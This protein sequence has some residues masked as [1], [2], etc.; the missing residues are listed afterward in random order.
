MRKNLTKIVI[1]LG[2]IIINLFFCSFYKIVLAGTYSESD[3]DKTLKR[4]NGNI[5]ANTVDYL[6]Y[7]ASNRQDAFFEFNAGGMIKQNKEINI[8]DGYYDNYHTSN[9]SVICLSPGDHKWAKTQRV[10][11]IMDINVDGVTVYTQSNLEGKEFSRDSK[12]ANVKKAIELADQLAYFSYMS[13]K[14]NETTQNPPWHYYKS[15]MRFQIFGHNSKLLSDT[16]GIPEVFLPS[17]MTTDAKD[18]YEDKLEEW[19]KATKTYQYTGRIVFLN[20]TLLTNANNGQNDCIYSGQQK[21]KTSLKIKKVDPEGNPLK[22]VE[23]RVYESSS[24]EEKGDW[25]FTGLTNKNGV[26]NFSGEK[27][28]WYYVREYKTISGY[29]KAN[30]DHQVVKLTEDKQPVK[31]V[32]ERKTTL[33]IIKKDQY[34]KNVSGI[35]FWIWRVEKDGTKTYITAKRTN[36]EGVIEYK[37]AKIGEQYYF[38]EDVEDSKKLGYEP[39]GNTDA[40]ITI[41]EGEN[42]FTI[43]N[44]LTKPKLTIIKKDSKTG[45]LLPGA[46][47][48]IYDDKGN[49]VKTD[50]TNEDGKIIVLGEV[51]KTYR[52]KEVVPPTGYNLSSENSKDVFFKEGENEVEF[53][54]EPISTPSDEKYE[55]K[56]VKVD[57]E[58]KTH[59]LE[60][61]EFKIV[62][63]IKTSEP[64]G[65]ETKHVNC[66]HVKFYHLNEFGQVVAFE[67]EHPEGHDVEVN[68]YA[69][70]VNDYYIDASGNWVKGSVDS[71]Y[72]HKTNSKGIISLKGSMPKTTQNNDGTSKDVVGTFEGDITAIEVSNSNYGY[73]QESGTEHKVVIKTG[74]ENTEIENDQELGNLVIHKIDKRAYDEYGAKVPL[75]GVEFKIRTSESEYLQLSDSNGVV[76]KVNGKAVIDRYNETAENGTYI[77]KYVKSK[78][79]ATTFVTDENGIIR[80]ENLEVWKSPD[81]KYTYYMDEIA[82]GEK[83]ELYYEVK[84]QEEAKDDNITLSDKDVEDTNVDIQ[85]YQRYV[86][87]AGYIW[88]D[89]HQGKNSL[90][91]SVYKE[92]TSDKRIEQDDLPGG[93]KGITI[94]LMQGEEKHLAT[95]EAI[96][97]DITDEIDGKIK[98]DYFFPSQMKP[99]DSSKGITWVNPDG[100]KIEIDKLSEYYIE[101][102]YNG[103]KYQSVPAV[104]NLSEYLKL[105]DSSKAEDKNRDT[106]NNNF[107]SIKGGNYKTQN[108]TQG[109]TST[110][111]GLT[112]KSGTVEEKSSTLVQNTKYTKE[113]LNGSVSEIEK[114]TSKASTQD[115]YEIVF[116]PR[117]DKIRKTI[118]YINLGIY[119]REQADLAIATDLHNIGMSIN[120]YNHTYYYQKRNPY[121]EYGEKDHDYNKVDGQ[122]GYKAIMDAFSVQA[123]NRYTDSYRNLSYVRE[124]LPSYIAYTK[125]DPDRE[126]KLQV[127]VNYKIVVKNQ[128]TL[129]NKV[130]LRNYYDENYELIGATV[131]KWTPGKEANNGIRVCEM[132]Q[133][134]DVGDKLEIILTFELKT[135]AICSLA[136]GNGLQTKT[137]TTEIITYSTYKDGNNYA[138]IDKDSAPD[139]STYGD[140]T[141]YEDDIDAAPDLT[142]KRDDSRKKVLTGTVF[143]DK[144]EGNGTHKKDPNKVLKTEEDKKD[145]ET[146]E[147][148]ANGQYE[149]HEGKGQNVRVELVKRE[150]KD[151]N[152]QDIAE[153]DI[154]TVK[155]GDDCKKGHLLYDLD[156]NG[157]VIHPNSTLNN[158]PSD[159]TYK[160]VGLVPGIYYIRYTYGTEEETRETVIVPANTK[161]TTQDHK[162]TII[163]DANPAK[164][165]I[166]NQYFNQV[167]SKNYDWKDVSDDDLKQQGSEGYWYEAK[168]IENYSAA[169]DD[170]K[171]RLD[172]N[173]ALANNK[174]KV[175]TDYDSREPFNNVNPSIYLMS[176]R[177]PWI[178]IAIEDQDKNVSTLREASNNGTPVYDANKDKNNNNESSNERL[179]S[180]YE[181]K[182]GIVERPR[183]NF[184]VTKEISYISVTLANGQVLVEGDPRK[185]GK[186]G[187]YLTYPDRGS[188]KIEI[189]NE[190]IEGAQLNVEYTIGVANL[191]DMNYDNPK[192]YIL[193][194]PNGEVVKTK[195]RWIDYMDKELA[196]V[197]NKWT[198]VKSFE[199]NEKGYLAEDTSQNNNYN[200][201]ISNGTDG[202]GFGKDEYHYTLT[203]APGEIKTTPINASKLLTT[204]KDMT[205]DNKVEFLNV[206]NSVGRFY[207]SNAGKTTDGLI[208][209]G[210]PGNNRFDTDDPGSEDKKDPDNNNEEPRRAEII[211][212]PPTGQVRIYYAIGISCLVLLVGG[213][214]LIKKKVLDK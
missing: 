196:L 53:E 87:L 22:G 108:G 126:G 82:M 45:K 85:N 69:D 30:P 156:E 72:V 67:P 147:Y 205:Y 80:I 78:E 125:E 132:E 38:K 198:I 195:I 84:T 71:A 37:D 165:A 178:C 197:D 167:E 137:N 1:I 112:Y 27:G 33:K 129:S 170:Y 146:G 29:V 203:V 206:Y 202:N 46:T 61:V 39:V 35:K 10:D 201:I 189:D 28:K 111:V 136:Q 157:N 32:N 66:Q 90:T 57:S 16:L 4:L 123:K 88:D 150:M 162:S 171:H 2:L 122:D 9:P 17:N 92:G 180:T 116:V 139:N 62:A 159:G 158:T 41:K 73:K 103:L 110:K 211:V 212:I 187:S 208:L 192:Y 117:R 209:H 65:T 3:N 169:I 130:K 86:D 11:C 15:I 96:Y 204:A 191:S 20:G 94:Q 36:K 188:L 76:N 52:V 207:E 98:R 59:T 174:Y 93:K 58:D 83:W 56:I 51:G 183:Q 14:N 135:R 102:Y 153:E 143:E 49:L 164:K 179:P 131:G 177:T 105:D 120:G 119:E 140:D 152:Y 97:M 42:S 186:I 48:E 13:I 26:V 200:Y 168:G 118:E 21:S 151:G 24:K 99:S 5:T 74:G 182:F 124:I 149:E 133:E 31:F 77:V 63:K 155:C 214:V 107:Y 144:I 81:E 34:D 121:F 115:Y 70:K 91:D 7:A 128:S 160:F 194:T 145:I 199:L 44:K 166:E 134:V 163:A 12:N 154:G 68:K 142:I 100:Y 173:D 18:F 19:K 55:I 148:K 50:E 23:I 141:T 127:F 89:G 190:I 60:G 181:T 8:R 101:F 210:T 75:E 64:D 106:I 6:Q 104:G 114:A 25:L 185:E 193:G 43:K 175:K 54:N 213:I 138:S 184:E 95:A 172:I 161:V 109:S 47:F 113:S 40:T 176:S 79:D